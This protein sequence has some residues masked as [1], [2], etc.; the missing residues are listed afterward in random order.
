VFVPVIDLCDK[1]ENF[2]AT[3]VGLEI[4]EKKSLNAREGLLYRSLIDGRFSVRK[5]SAR[6]STLSTRIGVNGAKKAHPA[7]IERR[8]QAK[9]Y[10]SG[11]AGESR[12]NLDIADVGDPGLSIISATAGITVTVYLTPKLLV[13]RPTHRRTQQHTSGQRRIFLHAAILPFYRRV[14]FGEVRL[15]AGL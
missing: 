11:E 9:D 4:I 3:F 10:V 13:K 5:W 15:G 7:A 2:V 8:A 14:R 12:V 1:P 6:D